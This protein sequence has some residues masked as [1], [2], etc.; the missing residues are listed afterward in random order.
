M[1]LNPAEEDNDSD[2]KEERSEVNQECED[3]LD[4]H[5]IGDAAEEISGTDIAVDHETNEPGHENAQGGKSEE[6]KD[7]DKE[8]A[9]GVA[10]ASSSA[11]DTDK[12][13]M[14][15]TDGEYESPINRIH[16]EI[17]ELTRKI[18]LPEAGLLN[19]IRAT[20]EAENE[21]KKQQEAAAASSP[22][23]ESLLLRAIAEHGSADFS[24]YGAVSGV[25]TRDPK[26]SS[27]SPWVSKT[28]AVGSKPKLQN[29]EG[30]KTSVPEREGFSTSPRK[31]RT[32]TLNGESV[33]AGDAN[34]QAQAAEELSRTAGKE[35]ETRRSETTTDRDMLGKLHVKPQL[36]V[37]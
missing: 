20:E 18:S 4:T 19:L 32:V 8:K 2:N 36:H 25:S 11:L 9:V 23:K 14:E 26:Q 1:I 10:T 7:E 21:A 22:S 5:D 33:T 24:L 12:L 13:Q 30:G 29:E 27:T 31:D 37:H 6:Q 15:E 17:L 35:T 34:V 3:D 28:P 16:S